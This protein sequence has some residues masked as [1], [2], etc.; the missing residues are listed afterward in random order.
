MR[1]DKMHSIT[2]GLARNSLLWHTYTMENHRRLQKC[3]SMFDG[4]DSHLDKHLLLCVCARERAKYACWLAG[5]G[6]LGRP[7]TT[8]SHRSAKLIGILV[9]SLATFFVFVC[10]A[11]KTAQTYANNYKKK[12]ICC[13]CPLLWLQNVSTLSM[14]CATRAIL[15]GAGC[16]LAR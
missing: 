3:H 12:R 16:L 7:T 9:Y 4:D 5:R 1:E 13:L 6:S 14:C 8:K 11:W 10:T 2:L 15:I